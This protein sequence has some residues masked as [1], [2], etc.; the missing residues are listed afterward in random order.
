VSGVGSGV[1]SGVDEV[2]ASE[3]TLIAFDGRVLEVF[4]LTDAQRMHIAFR[5]TI[6]VG[7]KL[8]TIKP[9]SGARLSFFYDSARA[10]DIAAFAARVHAAHP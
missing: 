8:V 4:G 10:D 9:T 2:W 1:G 7:S 3:S 5:P 6:T